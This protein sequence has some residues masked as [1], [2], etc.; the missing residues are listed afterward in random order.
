M[1]RG[2]PPMGRGGPPMGRGGPPMGRGGP[3]MGRGGPPMGRGG[4]IDGHWQEL[5]SAEYSEEGDTYW[6]DSRPPMRGM[7]PPFPPGRG[8]PPLGSSSFMQPGRGLPHHPVHGPMD[9]ESLGHGMNTG[10]ATM[11][12]DEQP[13]YHEHEP[14]NYPMH[15]EAGGGRPRVPPPPHEMMDPMGDTLYHEE[16]EKELGW[17]P[18]HGR[19]PPM[20]PHE[21]L[22]RG[23]MRRR[24]MGRGL[25]RGLGR[26]GSTNEEYKQE[27]NEGYVEDY[28]HGE[29]GYRWRPP[30]EYPP[31]N[32][33][34]EAKFHESEWNRESLPGR[35]YP[36]HIS[37][38][39]PYRDGHWRE[40][41][42][43]RQPYPYDEH[44]RGRELRIREY[45]DASPYSQEEQTR[46]PLPSEWDRSSRL[47]PPTDRGYPPD[48]EDR[49]PR[50]DDRR[51]EAP[52][53]IQP[54]PVEPVTNLP[55][56]SAEPSGANVLALSQRQH[57]II[58][59]AAQEL[60][61]IR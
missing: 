34:H 38:S 42:E 61:L 56:S 14:H 15:S 8:R 46:P 49:R 7:R 21:I 2:G 57:E 26:P 3:P 17:E 29:D 9:H 45:R 12:P 32:Y 59:K 44:D 50:Y 47:P 35:D 41:S 4:P 52:G 16:M 30:R 6:G 18:P 22:E 54:P 39:E 19:G 5:E 1:G 51:E 40:E 13:M 55:E 28:C 53:D 37:P 48:Y 25:A 31:E 58:L 20:P 43:R 23:G 10:D 36:P 60:K 27:C 33:R 11:D 24:P